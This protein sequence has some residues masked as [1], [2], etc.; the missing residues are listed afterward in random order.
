MRSPVRNALKE[1]PEGIARLLA[2]D[3]IVTRALERY[4]Y[5][6]LEFVYDD[7]VAPRDKRIAELET[8]LAERTP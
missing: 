1:S 8:M 2:V 7:L 5:Q 3:S 6:I 4:L